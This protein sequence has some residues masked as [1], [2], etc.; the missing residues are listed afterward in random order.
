MDGFHLNEGIAASFDV[1]WTTHYDR[2][3]I[4]TLMSVALKR[5]NPMITCK[6]VNIF[7][8]DFFSSWR[9]TLWPFPSSV[10]LPLWNLTVLID[11]ESQSYSCGDEAVHR[12]PILSP[13]IPLIIWFTKEN[14]EKNIY[15]IFCRHGH[16]QP[17]LSGGTNINKLLKI[18]F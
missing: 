17:A 4:R 1:L 2:I 5:W 6:H 8:K 18:H 15:S 16:H 7:L 14:K 10:T 11:V 9:R 12:A 3:E 13:V